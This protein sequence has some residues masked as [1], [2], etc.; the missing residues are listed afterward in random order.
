MPIVI[1]HNG[2]REVQL[3]PV[4]PVYALERDGDGSAVWLQDRS[5]TAMVV[6][7]S[8]CKGAK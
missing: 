3:D 8:T 7:G 4:A 6:H 1:A 5:G 2:S